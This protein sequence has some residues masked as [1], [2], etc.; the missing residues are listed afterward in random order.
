[1]ASVRE[2]TGKKGVE[3]VF[4]HVGGETFERSLRCS[5]GAGGWCSA[6]PPAAAEA[7]STCVLSSSRTSR[8]FGSTMGGQPELRQLL[9]FVASRI[10]RAGYRPHS[11]ARAGRR[12]AGGARESRAVRQDRADCGLTAFDTTDRRRKTPMPDIRQLTVLGSGTMGLGIAH[13]SALAGYETRLFDISAEAL[14]ARR[15]RSTATS[16]R[17]SRAARWRPRTRR[18]SS[19]WFD[20]EVPTAVRRPTW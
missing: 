12:G 8:S 3:V 11:A 9:E 4:D 5:P 2:I 10:A 6:A 18:P 17:A 19:S 7:T 20:T 13:V 16:P 1:M 14:G 15:R